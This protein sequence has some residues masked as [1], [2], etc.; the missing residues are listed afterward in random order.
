[1]SFEPQDEVAE[2]R[3]L[4]DFLENTRLSLDKF[5]FSFTTWLE[6]SLRISMLSE[7]ETLYEKVNKRIKEEEFTTAMYFQDKDVWVVYNTA[8]NDQ[9]YRFMT[10]MISKGKTPREEFYETRPALRAAD[11]RKL[12]ETLLDHLRNG[13]LD[14]SMRQSADELIGY[15]MSRVSA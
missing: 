4:A 10:T 11:F 14:D 13:R 3:E 9:V 15:H 8:Y 1:M 5:D 6:S 12:V 2:A 7:F